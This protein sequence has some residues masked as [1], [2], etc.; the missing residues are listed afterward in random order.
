MK[1]A[2][3]KHILSKY[4][5]VVIFMFF[6][7]AMYYVKMLSDF[8]LFEV[9]NVIFGRNNQYYSTNLIKS[10]N[11]IFYIFGFMVVLGIFLYKYLAPDDKNSEETTRTLEIKLENIRKDIEHKIREDLLQKQSDS[12]SEK[13]Y[14]ENDATQNDPIIKPTTEFTSEA[15]IDNTNQRNTSERIESLLR[16]TTNR[17]ALEINNLGKRARVNLTIG[18]LTAFAGVS[19]FILFVFEEAGDASAQLYLAKEFAPRISLVIVIEL[20]AYFFL[21]LYKTNLSEI[22]YFHNELTNIEMRRMAL[23]EALTSED[24]D[25]VM[26][27][28]RNIAKTERNFLLKKDES[29][30]SLEDRRLTLEEQKG[31]INALVNNTT[32][33]K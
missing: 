31:V 22:K 25:T 30:V 14:D 2:Y 5:M 7:T 28:I 17:L 12:H 29:T 33:S 15:Y 11:L 4:R 21:G 24:K 13:R 1:V 18:S 26:E 27:I 20:F 8:D 16:R 10:F 3:I 6:L 23:T 9:F 19:I 32:L